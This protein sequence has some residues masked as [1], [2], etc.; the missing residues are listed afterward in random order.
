MPTLPLWSVPAVL[1][2]A[3]P[4]A[5]QRIADAWSKRVEKRTDEALAAATPRD[6]RDAAD[7]RDE[8][9]ASNA[10][11]SPTDQGPDGSS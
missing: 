6:E 10:A 5:V 1:I 11:S 4:W 8:K 2:L 3:G 7:A 9:G